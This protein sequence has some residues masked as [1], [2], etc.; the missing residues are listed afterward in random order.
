M[1]RSESGK[2]FGDEPRR[3]LIADDN[4]DWADGLAALLEDE[5]YSV[6]TTYDGREALQAA[7]AFRPHIVLLDIR[8]PQMTGN[9]AA[10]IFSRHPS[11]TRPVLVAIT[12]WPED[13]KKSADGM[14]SFDHFLAKPA[15]H[16]AIL[17][18]L[19]DL[20]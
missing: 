16:T 7:A 19:K 5:G 9:E 4:R 3:V 17:A 13:L 11:S 10:R 18:L 12:A 8:M 20:P 2:P 1:A 14:H 6:R 15:D